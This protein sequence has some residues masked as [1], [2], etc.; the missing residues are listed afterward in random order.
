METEG[1]RYQLYS[2]R[3]LLMAGGQA[4]L[5]TALFGRMYYLGVVEGSQFAMLAED[6]RI[7]M[8]ILP[9]TR[10]EIFDRFGEKLATNRKDFRIFLIPEQANNVE[11]TLQRLHVIHPISDGQMR[12]INR[13]ISRQR[14]FLPVTVA[15]NLSW[16]EFAR[17]NVDSSHLPGIQPDAGETR[18]YPHG[19]IVSHV[20]GFVG[21][22]TIEDREQ[23]DDPV[24]QIPGFKLGQAALEQ[25]FEMP[26]R[27]SAGDAQEEVNAYGRVIRELTRNEGQRGQDVVLTLDLGLQTFVAERLGDQSAA[28]V[29]MDIITGD[30]LAMVSTPGFNSNDFNLGF[31]TENWE[32]LQRD[33]RHPL[34]NKCIAGQYPPGSTFKMVVAIAAL[35]SGVVG[36]SDTV[37]C[38]GSLEFGDR[39][40]YCWKD[41]GHGRMDMVN[42][43]AQS[44]DVYFYNIAN[45][46]GIDKINEV[47]RR[48]GFG[49]TYNIGLPG[50]R[51][52]LVPT[53]EWKLANF[54]D[55]WRPGETLIIGIGQGALLATPLQMATMVA[56]LANGQIAVE[57]RLV[58]TV[59]REVN[60]GYSRAPF[61]IDP[62]HL[63]VV[64]RGM[65]KV[66][67]PGGTAYR[68]RLRGDGMVM[69]GKTG[70]SQVR[71]ISAAQREAG[72][73]T[74]AERPWNE[75]DHAVFVGYA[76]V[77]APRYA[78]SVLVEHG[79]GGSSI[80]APIGRDIMREVLTRDPGRISPIENPSAVAPPAGLENT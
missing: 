60:Y 2:R 4:V 14:D 11:E 38:A 51:D 63:E 70:T 72:L 41:G 57:P 27:G 18:Y 39:T 35:E 64:R 48:F 1:E 80:A 75:R 74:L 40:F 37:R 26:L 67:E 71:G 55:Q 54:G 22:I 24:L 77:E 59:G 46:V 16:E 43:I 25:A 68:S 65:E 3:A 8:R 36:S 17:I 73:D 32:S 44:C 13:Q 21:A 52:G 56:R 6:N 69:A 23:D 31:S 30:V 19:E 49:E 34:M 53:R 45:R 9:P 42:A 28:A 78:V 5:A 61:E 62:E 58:N 7:S 76:P 33:P 20:V 29:V 12:R 50:Q 79:G 15:E 66:L 10:G 47:A